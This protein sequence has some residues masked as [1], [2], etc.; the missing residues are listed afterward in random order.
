MLT[1]GIAALQII[2]FSGRTLA[3]KDMLQCKDMNFS[4]S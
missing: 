1:P 3:Q 4:E 2:A